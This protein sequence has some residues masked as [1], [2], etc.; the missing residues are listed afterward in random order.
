MRLAALAFLACVV[1]TGTIMTIAPPAVAQ[2]SAVDR[3]CR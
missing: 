3:A 2:C 1:V